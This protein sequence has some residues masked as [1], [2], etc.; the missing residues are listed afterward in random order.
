M[1]LTGIG[2]KKADEIIAYRQQ[3]GNFKTIDDLKN[4]SELLFQMIAVRCHNDIFPGTKCLT[5][6][7]T[8]LVVQNILPW[9]FR[10]KLRHEHGH[11]VISIDRIF[12]DNVTESDNRSND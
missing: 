8:R 12:S 5:Q 2:D 1:Q 10:N 6:S 9:F 7:E 11:G 4:V 3:N